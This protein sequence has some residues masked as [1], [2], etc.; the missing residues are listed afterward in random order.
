MVNLLKN[1]IIFY[2]EGKKFTLYYIPCV[3]ALP[4][5]Y[6]CKFYIEIPS[7]FVID[8]SS[9]VLNKV[10]DNP[11]NFLFQKKKFICMKMN[12]HVRLGKLKNKLKSWINLLLI[13]YLDSIINE[14]SFVLNEY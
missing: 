5:K 2:I 6:L 14:L 9:P 1:F 4:C 8:R 10:L 12:G 3:Y 11:E 7:L 13:Q